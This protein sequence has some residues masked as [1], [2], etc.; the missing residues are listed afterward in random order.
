MADPTITINMT[1][2]GEDPKKW[3]DKLKKITNK[4]RECIDKISITKEQL[5]EK[6]RENYLDSRQDLRQ[7][8]QKQEQ[9]Q[10]KYR[11]VKGMV[12]QKEDKVNEWIEKGYTPIGGL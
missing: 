7:K 6:H 4:T 5:N 1:I 12:I 10:D 3:L 2:N 8:E 11:I 9:K